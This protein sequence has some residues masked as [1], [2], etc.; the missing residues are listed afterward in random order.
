MKPIVAFIFF[1]ISIHTSYAQIALRTYYTKDNKETKKTDDALYYREIVISEDQSLPLLIT[2][3]YT[4][5]DKLK[6]YGYYNNIKDKK[7]V[8]QKFQGYINSKIKAKEKFSSDGIKIDTAE[9]YHPNG[10]LK[11]AYYY[12]YHQENGKTIV[13]DTLI[14]TFQ[15]SLGNTLLTNGDGYAELYIESNTLDKNPNEVEKG[16]FKNHKRTGEWTGHFLNEKYHFVEQYNDGKILAGIT[17][18]SLNNEYPYN[19]SNF[20]IPPLYPGDIIALRRLVANKYNYPPLALK[21]GVNGTVIITFN[22]D[23]KGNMIDLKIDRDLGYG[24]GDEAMRVLKTARQWSPGI[25]RGIP[26]KVAYTLPL[27]LNTN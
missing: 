19:E 2:E 1:I 7:F 5:T 4:A 6:L 18:D 24:T 22:I 25:K 14:L 26:V 9:Y 8:G 21:N 10:K 27:R 23:Q 15:D 3:K 20:M 11:L 16:H 17:K 13:T 12:P